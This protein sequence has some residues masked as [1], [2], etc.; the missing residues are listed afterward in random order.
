MF[1][2]SIVTD[3]SFIVDGGHVPILRRN[4]AAALTDL[5]K[6]RARQ[7]DDQTLATQIATVTLDSL[8]LDFRERLEI[9]KQ[10]I[11]ESPGWSLRLAIR[12]TAAEL[13]KNGPS[14]NQNQ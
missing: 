10:A 6:R 7:R 9:A 12:Q 13:R 14:E 1:D 4:I 8:P 11:E 5:E 2:T 3:L